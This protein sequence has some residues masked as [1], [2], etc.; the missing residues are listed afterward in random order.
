[1]AFAKHA[2]ANLILASRTKSKLETVAKQI[3]EQSPGEKPRL[4]VVDLGS[5][6][7][8]KD[9]AKE[10]FNLV[11][12]IDILVNNAAVTS[13]ERRETI[14]GLESQFGTNYVGPFLFTHLLTP[15]LKAASTGGKPRPGMTRVVNVSSDGYKL[16]P[17]RFH[18]YNFE[19]KPVPVEEQPPPEIPSYMKPDPANGKNYYG[20]TAYGQSKTANI[21]HAMSIRQKL[22]K[23]GVQGFAV[24]PGT[25]WTDLSRSLDKTDYDFIKNFPAE[26]KTHDEGIST[27]LVAALDPKLAG[28]TDLVYLSD[29]QLEDVSDFAKDAS[30]AEKLWELSEKL[31]GISAKLQ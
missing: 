22:G 5:L 27:I 2:P 31:T 7:S 4:I 12:H 26:W 19:G 25:I 23:D 30:V 17:I 6:A 11:G 24:H 18:D 28:Q 20:F 1:M 14:D 10:V 15:L 3:S 8:V 29:C 13:S 16:S 9:A 21:L